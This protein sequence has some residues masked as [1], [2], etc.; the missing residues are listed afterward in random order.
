MNETLI[1]ISVRTK[2]ELTPDELAILKYEI[3]QMLRSMEFSPD[4]NHEKVLRVFVK[5]DPAPSKPPVLNIVENRPAN[6]RERLKDEGKP[7]PRSGCNHCKKRLN[8]T[9]LS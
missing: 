7:H 6:C 3:G 4:P 2:S 9:C 1:T 8:Q 5:D